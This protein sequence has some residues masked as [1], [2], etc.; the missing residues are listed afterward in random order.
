MPLETSSL[1]GVDWG[2]QT[3]IQAVRI[4]DFTMSQHGPPLLYG[5]RIQITPIHEIPII[6]N[7]DF[8]YSAL[9]RYFKNTWQL[10]KMLLHF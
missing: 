7:V 8:L 2:I 9:S 6:F 5:S 4:S 3:K 1:I 10:R